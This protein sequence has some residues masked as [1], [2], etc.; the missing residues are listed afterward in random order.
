MPHLTIENLLANNSEILT[1]YQN[2]L[3]LWD[4]IWQDI[5]SENVEGLADLLT[6]RQGR[7]E[8]QCHDRWLGQEIM[9]WSGFSMLYDTNFGFA[10]NETRARRLK[11]AFSR[12]YCSGEV[13]GS[14]IRVAESYHLD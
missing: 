7:F 10:E 3:R 1:H 12:S 2:A 13:K 9:V 8:Q 4:E 14:A 6:N 11:D 5:N